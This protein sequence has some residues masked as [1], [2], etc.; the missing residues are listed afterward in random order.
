VHAFACECGDRACDAELRLKVGAV[1][2]GTALAPG[3]G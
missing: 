2:T 1:A 3:H